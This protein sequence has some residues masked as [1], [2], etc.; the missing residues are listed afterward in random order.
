MPDT[1]S[2]FPDEPASLLDL[3]RGST[4]LVI[5]DDSN[6]RD[7]LKRLLQKDGHR[8]LTAEDGPSGLELARQE[9]PDAITLDVVMPGGMDG[10]EVLRLLKESPAT[11]AIPVIMVSVMA[12]QEHALT[13]EVEDYLVKPIDVDRLARAINR[14]THRV[15]QRNLLL[16]DDE[17]DSLA[18]MSRILEAAGWHTITASNGSEALAALAKTRPAAI[19]LDLLMPEMDGFEFLQHLRRDPQ[20]RTIPVLV[21]SGKDPTESEQ[22][23]LRDRVDAV[24]KKGSHSAEE[25]LATVKSRLRSRADS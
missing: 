13:L 3:P 16:V 8:V 22:A 15:P 25:L 21:M 6:V 19:I 14:V 11:N 24:M 4:I 10:W 9:K 23:F 2:A 1:P 17:E 20:M 5:D 18:S 12:E 7:L